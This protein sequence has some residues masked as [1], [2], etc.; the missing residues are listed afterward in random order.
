[1]YKI[2][3][4]FFISPENRINFVGKEKDCRQTKGTEKKYP[5][6]ILTMRKNLLLFIG[7][8]WQVNILVAQ[9][10]IPTGLLFSSQGQVDSFSINFPNCTEVEGGLYFFGGDD[11]DITNLDGLNQ[12]V[13]IGENLH[14]QHVDSLQTLDGLSNLQSIGGYLDINS[15][16]NLVDISGLNNLTAVGEGINISNNS[17]LSEINGFNQITAFNGNLY[18]NS[19][20]SL[21][22]VNGFNGIESIDR[23]VFIGN[24]MLTN[25]I[26]LG[27]L[28]VVNIHMRLTGNFS[29]GAFD[30]CQQLQTIENYLDIIDNPVLTSLIGFGALTSIG[31]NFTIENNESLTN[32][33]DFTNLTSVGG[34]YKIENNAFLQSLTPPNGVLTIVGENIEIV[35]NPALTDLSGLSGINQISELFS[36]NDNDALTD[37]TGVNNITTVTSLSLI[38]ND[39]LA[40]LS[41]FGMLDSIHADLTMYRQPEIVNFTGMSPVYIQRLFLGSP[42]SSSMG[43]VD[44]TGLENLTAIDRITAIQCPNLQN[45]SGLNNVTSIS[46][47]T[48]YINNSLIDFTGL[49][50]VTTIH[51]MSII[52]NGALA[53]CNGLTNLT[54]VTGSMNFL[55]H[56]DLVDFTGLGN[57]ST[58]EQG[59]VIQ[60]NY[61]LQSL[62]GL[63]NLSTVGSNFIIHNNDLLQDISGI[64]NVL[65]A[66]ATDSLS[67]S[68]NSLLSTCGYENICDYV[69]GGGN[70]VVNDNAPGCSDLN[71]VIGSCFAFVDHTTFVGNVYADL[72]AD[73]MPD[74]GDV[75]LPQAI[76]RVENDQ[77]SYGVT[78]DSAGNYALPVLAGEYSLNVVSPSTFWT[79]CFTDSLLVATAMNDSITTDFYMT[80]YGNCPY[81]DWDMTLPPLRIC[82]SRTATISYCNF[83]AIPAEDAVFSIQLDTFVTLDSASIPYMLGANGEVIFE[84]DTIDLFECGQFTMS[85]FLDC[86]SVELNEV[87]CID[88]E[89]LSDTLC[90][91]SGNWD[92]SLITASGYCENDS[93]YFIL[94]NIGTGGMSQDAQFRVD[95]LIEDIV[96]LHDVDDYQLLSGD[97]TI[98]SYELDNSDGFRIEADQTPGHPIYSEASAVVPNCEDA[99]NDLL[100]TLVPTNNGDPFSETFCTVAVNSYDPNIKSTTPAGLGEEHFIDSD[101]ELDY[102]IQFQNTGNDVAYQ[103][104]IKDTLSEKLDWSTLRVK[105]ASHSFT[106]SL[107][108][109]RE[110]VF[111]FSDINL[112]DSTSNE[113][114]SHGYVQYSILPLASILP[115]EQ[116]E[117][118]AGIY[119]DFNEPIITNTVF[120]TI[121]KPVVADSEN[122]IWC[123]GEDFLGQLI[124]Q[125]TSVQELIE[126]AFYDSIQVYHL[127]VLPQ[128]FDST[129]IEVPFGET[130]EGALITGDTSFVIAYADQNNCDSLVAYTVSALVNL[131]EVGAEFA[132]VSI[133][134]NPATEKILVLRHESNEP[135]HWSLVNPLGKL[136]WQKRLNAETSLVEISVADLP[137]GVYWLRVVTTTSGGV[138]PIAVE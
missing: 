91:P 125:D 83:G 38:G 109:Q 15:N 120:H 45:F 97:S 111:V 80:P 94:K 87:L 7:L 29:L 106:W 67:I 34:T 10:C 116:I 21:T 59:L 102:T 136:V 129:M 54:T 123:A 40:D 124:T 90:D 61:N 33:S 52:Q 41:P 18:I 132:E 105:G 25:V 77:Y 112:P 20:N 44:F 26:G 99:V 35:S 69:L 84:L 79:P 68:S 108:P 31:T 114:E 74:A 134:P 71:D 92:G 58:I 22:T 88:V 103:V 4:M 60:S 46:D 16:F 137:P 1:M 66:G 117:N 86:D 12:I 93:V 126:F 42:S 13:S 3:K 24:S 39:L 104:V 118:R 72:D 107:N 17:D 6:N 51:D 14:I 113:P 85:L 95:I 127:E 115:G 128:S 49:E 50:N 23:L 63:E 11:G 133:F 81:L 56:T 57:L 119:F 76:V 37:L 73:C 28:T 121:R 27:A 110:L 8:W 75:G 70:A 62:N 43:L 48:L 138:W 101:W 5:Q 82:G 100:L 30:A 53:N 19:N 96:L 55:N 98:L 78:A 36:L 89:L 122:L 64:E 135:Q 9:N 32:L 65:L 130:F 2:K 47:L 131:N